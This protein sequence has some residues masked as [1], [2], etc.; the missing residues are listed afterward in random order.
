MLSIISDISKVHNIII[1]RNLYMDF[2]PVGIFLGTQSLSNYLNDLS[3]TYFE[4]VLI[5]IVHVCMCMYAL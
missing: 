2:F 5:Q 1:C 4:I 3:R